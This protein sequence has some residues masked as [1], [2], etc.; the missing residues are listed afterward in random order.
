MLPGLVMGGPFVRIC[1]VSETKAAPELEPGRLS[2]MVMDWR[3]ANPLELKL[4]LFCN[5]V[6]YF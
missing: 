6:F 4:N 1:N 3:I 5:G 2:W